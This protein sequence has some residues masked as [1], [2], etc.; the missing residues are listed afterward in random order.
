MKKK[1]E[2]IGWKNEKYSVTVGVRGPHQGMG[3]Y[4]ILLN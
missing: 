4:W 1:D 2:Q 3:G